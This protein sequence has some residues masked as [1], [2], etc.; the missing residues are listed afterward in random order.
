M[1]LPKVLLVQLPQV[2]LRFPG[3][4]RPSICDPVSMSC[5]LGCSPTP[6]TGSPF[7]DRPVSLLILLLS[8]CRS[9]TLVAMTTPLAFCQG[10]FPMRSRALTVAPGFAAL[11]LLLRYARQV[12]PPPAPAA[13]A[14][15]W[16]CASAPASPPRS[17]PLPD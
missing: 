3:N 17:P 9:S 10:P 14:N 1:A 6:L 12:L 4:A 13:S 2:K 5:W 15:R 8:L 7:S 11:V 16:Q